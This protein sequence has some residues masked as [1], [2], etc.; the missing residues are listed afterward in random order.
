MAEMRIC[1][2]HADN[3]FRGDFEEKVIDELEISLNFANPNQHVPDIK[4]ASRLLEERFRVHYYR[5]P[6]EV[7]PAAMVEHLTMS[8]TDH[9]TW[10]PAKGGVSQHYSPYTILSLKQIDF[11]KHLIYSFGDYVQANHV[12]KVKN[13]NLLRSIDCIYL[14]SLSSEQ[15]RH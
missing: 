8:I 9:I 13:N 12:H 2:I 5:M 15:G 1:T 14:C 11:K 6:F 4:C 10:F 7:I 3:E